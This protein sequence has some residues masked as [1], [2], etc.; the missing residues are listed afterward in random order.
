MHGAEEQAGDDAQ[1]PFGP[2]DGGRADIRVLNRHFVRFARGKFGTNAL[3][4]RDSDRTVRVIVGR[5]GVGKTLYIR[6]LQ[7][8]A[9]KDDS[10]YADGYQKGVPRTN[11][12]VKVCNWY[13]GSINAE[14]WMGIWKAAIMR[15]LVSHVINSD[16]FDAD[17]ALELDLRRDFTELY[18]DFTTPHSITSQ[19]TEI[20]RGSEDGD[21]LDAYIYHRKWEAL[22]HRLGEALR[23]APPT[24]FYVDAID[25]EFRH[26]PRY[27]LMCQKGLF[28]QVLDFL[29]NDKFGGRLHVAICIRDH[30]FSATQTTEHAT[31]YIGSPYIKVLN[32]RRQD[33][34]YF[35]RQKLES[36]DE[37]W[38]VNP[39]DRTVRCWL[40][41]GEIY[42]AKRDTTE[43]I[44][45]YLLRHTR[46]I[47]RDI[48][49]L[50]NLICERFAM[51]EGER[52]SEEEIR[53]VVKSAARAFGKEQLAITANQVAAELM[54]G[55]AAALGYD[56]IFTGEDADEHEG[57]YGFLD[58]LQR[59]IR[60][61]IEPVKDDRF[62]AHKMSKLRERIDDQFDGSCDV[63]STLWQNGL[64]GYVDG[65][66]MTSS[67]VFYE[68][69]Q[70]DTLVAPLKKPGYV[71]HPIMIDALDGI[72]GVGEP[73]EPGT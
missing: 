31:K 41:L 3:G 44:E 69:T 30:V 61:I 37:D 67:A 58:A 46:L 42:N 65:P 43:D 19:L 17:A 35:L 52:L 2:P 55:D 32:W 40:G 70:E 34:R 11:D 12:V 56:N 9:A 21:E 66:L 51:R 5:K 39:D 23:E 48:V 33:I 10:L 73:V 71:L 53:A 72:N 62:S 49:V 16:R 50:G 29:D 68:P 25:E 20:L 13:A 15:S 4:M 54:P 59:D 28:Y 14:K 57:G 26:A 8:A 60:E 7:A 64:L 63:L 1:R 18:P 24:C 38:F 36:M 27:W 47:P 45:G 22:S 6:R